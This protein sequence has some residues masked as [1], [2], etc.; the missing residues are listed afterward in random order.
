MNM[1]KKYISFALVLVG[2]SSSCAYAF[3]PYVYVGGQLGWGHSNWS[4][5]TND[6]ADDGGVAYAG[7]IGYQ[8][9]RRFGAEAGGFVLPKTDITDLFV[10][11]TGTIKSW[12]GYGAMTFRFPLTKDER[13]FLRGKVGPA[14]RNLD[15][16]GSL[17]Y[18]GTGHYW[19]AILGASINYAFKNDS[20]NPI[21][22]GF[23]YSNVFGSSDWNSSNGNINP[24]AAPS[25]QVFAGT[26]SL[27]FKL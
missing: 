4:D 21:I 2:L 15:H 22:L 14:Y 1:N 13:L 26:L 18:L 6:N 16:S 12:V 25:A 17:A 7:K 9:T 23:E 11:S 24:N 20:P 19:T 27:A 8:A 3:D 10:S 5:F